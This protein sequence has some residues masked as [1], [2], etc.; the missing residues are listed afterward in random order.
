VQRSEQA[1][2]WVR[3][4]DWRGLAAIPNASEGAAGLA[5]RFRADT[6]QWPIAICFRT[7]LAEYC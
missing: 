4:A 3:R 2:F 5:D 7:E 6:P 1:E